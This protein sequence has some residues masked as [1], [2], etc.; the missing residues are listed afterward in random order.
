ME[1]PIVVNRRVAQYDVYIGRG[2][3][4]GNPFT[5]MSGPTKAQFHVASRTEALSQYRTYI[6]GQPHLL[7]A[8]PELAGCRLGCYCKPL[9]CHGDV[10]VEL[11]QERYAIHR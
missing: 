6:L 10:L 11:I 1:L 7:A 9:A 4:W 5:H 3:K 8:L 2:S